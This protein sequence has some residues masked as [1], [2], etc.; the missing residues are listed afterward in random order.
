MTDSR[1]LSRPEAADYLTSRGLRISKLT[2]QKL[3]STGG[4]PAYRLFCNSRAVY[5]KLDLDAWADSKLTCLLASS[6]APRTQRKTEL[7]RTPTC[8]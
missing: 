6:S 2:L 5:L 1:F 3:A 4:G 8:G 7:L